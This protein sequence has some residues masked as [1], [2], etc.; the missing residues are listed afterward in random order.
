MVFAP[1]SFMAVRR[2][3][4]FGV[5]YCVSAVRSR[6]AMIG[7]RKRLVLSMA[8]VSR[9]TWVSEMSRWK[10]VG[11]TFSIGSAVKRSA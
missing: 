5:Q 2:W 8:T 4:P 1:S 11:A 3:Y 9:R 7:S 6:T 10:G